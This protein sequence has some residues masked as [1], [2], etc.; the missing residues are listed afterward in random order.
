MGPSP[1]TGKVFAAP[2]GVIGPVAVAT[3]DDALPAPAAAVP[4]GAAVLVLAPASGSGDCCPAG[5]REALPG[6]SVPT[7]FATLASTAPLRPCSVTA[8]TGDGGCGV[9]RWS[10]ADA[11]PES[12]PAGCGDARAAGDE[13]LPRLAPGAPSGGS[14]DCRCATSCSNSFL[15]RVMTTSPPLGVADANGVRCFAPLRFETTMA[16]PWESERITVD[17]EVLRL[18]AAAAPS[19]LGE[20]SSRVAFASATN[21]R[22]SAV[23]ALPAPASPAPRFIGV[24]AME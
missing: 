14:G 17:I 21:A 10:S 15:S 9:G 7:S 5:L 20:S 4:M 18:A 22:T 12:F 2:R 19:P 8:A 1:P 23:V 3:S 16:A 6:E 13:P 24:S 11:D